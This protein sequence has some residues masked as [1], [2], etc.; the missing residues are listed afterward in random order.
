MATYIQSSSGIYKIINIV[1]NKIYIG[2]A[3]NIR[4]RKNGHVYDLRKGVHKND[5][6]QKAWNKHGEVNFKFEVVEICDIKLLHEKE[7]FWV[8]YYNCLDRT[9]GYN[10]KPTDPKGCSIHSEET[11]EKLRQANKGKKPGN[12]VKVEIEGTIYESL[13]EAS[14]KTGINLSTLRNRIKSKNVKYLNYKIYDQYERIKNLN[15]FRK[16]QEKKKT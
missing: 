7:H 9:K 13:T 3:S 4:T 6:L 12:I 15:T 16:R 2:C 10:L 14:N 1:N 8:N 5:Y 11:R